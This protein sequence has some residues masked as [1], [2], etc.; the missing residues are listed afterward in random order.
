MVNFKALP[1]GLLYDERIGINGILDTIKK[2]LLSL[3][4]YGVDVSIL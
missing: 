2:D 1:R 4:E 3:Q